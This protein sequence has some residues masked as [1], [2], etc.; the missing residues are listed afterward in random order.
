MV[1]FCG[2]LT[3]KVATAWAQNLALGIGNGAFDE[4]GRA[5]EAG[6]APRFVIKLHARQMS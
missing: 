6:D 5:V 4:G 1:G 3:A 2:I